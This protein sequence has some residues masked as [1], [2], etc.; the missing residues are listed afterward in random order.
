MRNTKRFASALLSILL[1]CC[2]FLFTGCKLTDE[3]VPGTYHL[4]TMS[5]VENNTTVT[6][7]LNIL[8]NKLSGYSM[9]LVLHEDGTAEMIEEIENVVDVHH[10]HVWS[11]DGFN[12]YATL[13]VVTD[14]KD[15]RLLRSKIKEELKE[16]GIG[17]VTIEFE[18]VGKNISCDDHIDR[19]VLAFKY[20]SHH[21]RELGREVVLGD[22]YVV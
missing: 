15:T 20:L 13:H 8:I 4:K 18:E 17:H 14:L 11:L 16:H 10:V 7:N 1:F 21:I 19:G 12:H 2:C 22:P 3:S 6:V 5:Y 9:R